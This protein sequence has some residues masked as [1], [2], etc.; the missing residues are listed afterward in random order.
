[1][2]CITLALLDKVDGG[3]KKRMEDSKVLQDHL[4]GKAG[5]D[6][7][8]ATTDRRIAFEGVKP[9]QIDVRER[10]PEDLIALISESDVDYSAPVFRIYADPFNTS[11]LVDDSLT[12][13]GFIIKAGRNFDSPEDNLRLLRAMKAGSRIDSV[14]RRGGEPTA[15][16]DSRIFIA[17]YGS[18][19]PTVEEILK[20]F[21]SKA[22]K[23]VRLHVLPFNV[24]N[25]KI[26][27]DNTFKPNAVKLP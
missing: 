21:Q 12:G 27:V 6:F 10:Q 19:H 13:D 14:F 9:L 4:I 7:L 17:R 26:T 22:R 23:A 1:M 20:P 16:M 25:G 3:L 2:T 18:H 11:S 5:A 24:R 8:L 15:L